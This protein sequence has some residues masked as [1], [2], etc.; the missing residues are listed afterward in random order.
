MDIFENYKSVVF[1][2]LLSVYLSCCLNVLPNFTYFDNLINSIDYKIPFHRQF[3]CIMLSRPMYLLIK[4][5]M[6]VK[7]KFDY[8]TNETKWVDRILKIIHKLH[9]HNF[10]DNWQSIVT[11]MGEVFFWPE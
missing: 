9:L 11:L 10:K 1:I 2:F 6:F 5:Y 8:I 7:F 3:A 4:S